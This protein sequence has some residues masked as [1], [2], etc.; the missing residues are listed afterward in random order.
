MLRPRSKPGVSSWIST[1]LIL[2]SEPG[3]PVNGTR[4]GVAGGRTAGCVLKANCRMYM[5][6]SKTKKQRFW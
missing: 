6:T 3:N 2:D 1:P 4:F 5:L